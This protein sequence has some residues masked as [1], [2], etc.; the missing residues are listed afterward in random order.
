MRAF[1]L[2]ALILLAIGSAPAAAQSRCADCHFANMDT[3]FAQHISDWER[4]AHGAA[5]VGCENCH[6]GDPSTFEPLLAHR[7]VLAPVH[8]AS[9]IH[10]LNV[11]TTCGKCHTG[12]FVEFQKSRHFALVRA[13]DLDAP[14]CTTC[15]GEVGAELLSPKGLEGECARC[16]GAGKR[17]ERSDYPAQGRLMLQSVRDVRAQLKEA[18]SLIRRVKDGGRRAA[19]E[20][21]AEQVRVPLVEAA[22]AGHQ[23]VFA[24]L[25]ERLATART[26]VSALLDRL[27]NQ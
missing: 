6:G 22:R 15:H 24:D 13:G 4:S 10:R 14:T 23:F 3:S 1:I 7:G 20:A 16:H 12:P 11:A 26:R 19:L 2:S 17:H 5:L 27:A 21:A 18:E 25:E 9:P 8:R